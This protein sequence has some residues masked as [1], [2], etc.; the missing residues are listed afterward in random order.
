M[1]GPTIHIYS[2]RYLTTKF[3]THARGQL[4]LRCSI[5]FFTDASPVRKLL[6]VSLSSSV[7]APDD[8]ATSYNH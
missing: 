5:F 7:F 6:R 4:T 3:A 8:S 2:A 1:T